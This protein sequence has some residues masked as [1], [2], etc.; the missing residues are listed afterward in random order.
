V[1]TIDVGLGAD[2]ELRGCQLISDE[3]TGRDGRIRKALD[4]F[5]GSW[6]WQCWTPTGRIGIGLP[7]RVQPKGSFSAEAGRGAERYQTIES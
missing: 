1:V 5:G 4:G 7:V 6:R 3:F 2:R